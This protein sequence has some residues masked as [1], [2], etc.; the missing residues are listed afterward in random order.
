LWGLRVQER[1]NAAAALYGWPFL[2]TWR[3]FRETATG[4]PAITFDAA[5]EKALRQT[6]KGLLR[7]FVS[8]PWIGERLTEDV[9]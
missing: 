4:Q 8:A 7:R 2:L 3:G 9:D 6:L 1:V 5:T